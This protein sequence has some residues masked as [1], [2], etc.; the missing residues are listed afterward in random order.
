MPRDVFHTRR[1]KLSKSIVEGGD[2]SV[3]DDNIDK[4]LGIEDNF[5]DA[6]DPYDEE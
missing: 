5:D 3:V 6:Y 2:M 1:S 4:C